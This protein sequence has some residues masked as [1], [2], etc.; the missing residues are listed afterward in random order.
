MAK[1]KFQRY[2]F[3]YICILPAL[4]LFIVFF[5]LPLLNGFLISFQKI[6]GMGEREFVGLSNYIKIFNDMEFWNSLRV[7]FVFTVFFILFSSGLGL[8]LAMYLVQKRKFYGFILVSFFIP[9]IST[10][11]IGALVWKNILADPYGISNT[12]LVS[13]GGQSIPWFKNP[14]LAMFSLIIIQ[15][16]YTLGYNAILFMSGL[17]AIPSTYFEAADLEGCRFDQKL[18][19]II[20]PLLIPTIVFVLTISTLYGFVN[21]YILANLI[22]NNGPFQATNVVMSYIFDLAFHRLELARANA[23]TMI[24]FILFLFLTYIQFRFQNKN[25]DGLE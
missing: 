13:L 16:W 12:L 10:P 20:L 17:Q 18:R 22:T 9:Y 2:L 4:L 7:S 23:A 5:L 15:V 14:G 1:E 19:Y 6:L 25:F 21:S 24:I 3:G 11:V 8:F